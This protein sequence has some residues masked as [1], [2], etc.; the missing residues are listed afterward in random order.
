MGDNN[1]RTPGLIRLR[2]HSLHP[3]PLHASTQANMRVDRMENKAENFE[4]GAKAAHVS[5]LLG[6]MA[7]IQGG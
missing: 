4:R 2:S 1:S 7:G 6:I 3:P 5:T